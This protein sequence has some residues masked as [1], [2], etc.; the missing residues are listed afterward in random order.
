M[1]YALLAFFIA[2]PVSVALKLYQAWVLLPLWSWFITP[3]AGVPAPSLIVFAG[4][5]LAVNA[6]FALFSEGKT[7][8]TT[9]NFFT[10]VIFSALYPPFALATGWVL[11]QFV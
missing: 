9:K 1:R 4:F 3:V 8:N 2:L 11:H 6:P 10:S 5:L 7:E